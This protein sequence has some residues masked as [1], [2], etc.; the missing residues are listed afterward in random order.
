MLL[1]CQFLFFLWKNLVSGLL[2]TASGKARLLISE[3]F[4]QFRALCHQNLAWENSKTVGVDNNFLNEPNTLITL[5][6]DLD[7]FWAMVSLQVDDIRGLFKQVDSLRA[8]NWQPV[9]N[10]LSATQNI[11]VG[12]SI[13]SEKRKVLFASFYLK[14]FVTT[15][16]FL[17]MTEL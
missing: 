16:L 5:V 7:G 12:D 1:N 8:N 2:R 17:C 4:C 15:G 11:S 9:D 6:S 3:K 14:I 10:S 13:S